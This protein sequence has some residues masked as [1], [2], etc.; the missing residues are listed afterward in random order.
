MHNSTS[1]FPPVSTLSS[2]Q[3]HA[4][5]LLAT[6]TCLTDRS[7]PAFL[8]RL[9]GE[10]TGGRDSDR[11]ERP[12]ARPRGRAKQP[13]DDE[14]DG[15]TYVLEENG[16][17]LSKAE[18][19]ALV[20]PGAA[21][22]TDPAADATAAATSADGSDPEQDDGEAAAR[23]A[24]RKPQQVASVGAASKKRKA[25]K[26]GQDDDEDEND[27]SKASSSSTANKP[28]PKL[29]SSASKQPKAKK[30]KK[31]KAKVALS[32]GDEAE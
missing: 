20:N 6:P 32:F 16:D 21:T 22:S 26:I 19:E 8:R 31:A 27:E 10:A 28:D 25:M 24:K 12:V 13:G 1:S 4:S 15:P 2:V 3:L 7:E 11:H 18:Y 9:K 17:A 29:A 30:T 23:S 5:N 14:E